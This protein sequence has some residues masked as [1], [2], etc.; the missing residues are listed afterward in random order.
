[1]S[2]LRDLRETL[3]ERAATVD[4]PDRY[5]RPVAVRARIRAAR[6]RRAVAGGVAA[7]LV[8][9]AGVTAAGSLG[10]GPDRIEPAGTVVL[11]VDVPEDV[12]V[13]GFPYELTGTDPLQG[14][15]DRV[16]IE[17]A[18]TPQAVSLVARDLGPGTAT[19]YTDGVAVARVS[20][21]E[22]SVPVPVWEGERLRVRLDGADGDARTGLAFYEGTGEPAPGVSDGAETFREQVSGAT[23]L[24]AA[25][26]DTG[27]VELPYDGALSDLGI[28]TGCPDAPEGAHLTVEIDGEPAST[29]PCV[30]NGEPDLGRDRDTPGDL[31]PGRRHTVRAVLTDGKDGPV[32]SDGRVALGLYRPETTVVSGVDVPSRIEMYGRTWELDPVGMTTVRADVDW[33]RTLET[34]TSDVLVGFAARGDGLARLRWA[35]ELSRGSSSYVEA[36]WG[37]SGQGAL[38]LKGDTYR[39]SFDAEDLRDASLLVYRPV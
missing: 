25:F 39:I 30:W 38:L 31:V 2:T 9:A 19:L 35:G 23:L 12:R 27:E 36:T 3:D 16:L 33:S 29:G 8:L 17:P 18:A 11:G 21:G 4:D 6:Q 10:G 26:S 32:I 28:A 7:A 34:G 1:M 5:A 14:P 24:R 13:H 22:V 20:E 37:A 15:D